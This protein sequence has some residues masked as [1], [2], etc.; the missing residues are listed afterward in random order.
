MTLI[1][2][3]YSVA[4]LSID[5]TPLKTHEL[6]SFKIQ[7]V[8]KTW[9]S[10]VGDVEDTGILAMKV[11]KRNSNR[12]WD[13]T[14]RQITYIT[15]QYVDSLESEIV[16]TIP[17]LKASVLGHIKSIYRFDYSRLEE[18]LIA[19]E[20]IGLLTPMLKNSRYKIIAGGFEG[21]FDASFS[22]LSIVDK[23]HDEYVTIYAGYTE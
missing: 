7:K 14:L 9:M 2:S 8:I 10:R 5:F 4:S 16:M 15:N 19:N 23:F 1:L 18:R 12:N 17:K 3:F 22:E 11:N 13:S 20:L 6:K 21:V